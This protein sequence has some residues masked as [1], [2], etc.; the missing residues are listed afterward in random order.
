MQL[1]SI[2]SRCVLRS[3]HNSHWG[4]VTDACL[5]TAAAALV[6]APYAF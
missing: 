1:P 6:A 3:S 5:T 2:E 4:L